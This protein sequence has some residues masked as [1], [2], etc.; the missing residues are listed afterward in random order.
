MFNGWGIAS[1]VVAALMG[2]HIGSSLAHDNSLIA[3]GLN[4]S[5]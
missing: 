3:M 2:Y 1:V 4:H 5:V